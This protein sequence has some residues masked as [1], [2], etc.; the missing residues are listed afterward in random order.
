[1]LKTKDPDIEHA[2]SLGIAE[3]QFASRDYTGAK[4]QLLKIL[5]KR[6][7][8]PEALKLL[9]EIY[10]KEGRKGKGEHR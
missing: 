2:S 9:N 4:I 1:M 8:D 3:I 5:N 7:K 6:P 10:E